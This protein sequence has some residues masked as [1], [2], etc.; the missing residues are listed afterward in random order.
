MNR[1]LLEYEMK[2]RGITVC[3]LCAL[4][5]FSKSAYYRKCKGVSEFTLDE[6]KK[7]VKCLNLETPV[8]IF[9]VDK[10]S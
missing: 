2:K 8:D 10:V 7:I 4:V 5:G 3:D 9:F 1:A 6:I